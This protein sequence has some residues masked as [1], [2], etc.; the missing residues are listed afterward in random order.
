MT[1]INIVPIIPKKFLSLNLSK[2]IENQLEE[3][4]KAIKVD[5]EVTTRTWK[6]RPSFFI[7]AIPNG[8]RIYTDN[9]VYM[10]IDRGTK[11]HK[12]SARNAK[13][14]AFFAGGFRAK[15]RPRFIGSNKGQVANKN[16]TFPQSVNHPG[17]PAREYESTIKDKWDKEAP[18]QFLRALRAELEKR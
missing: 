7:K 9:F 10:L 1:E 16:L 14:L 12:I 13:T 4:A 18:R 8:R 3:T 2:V 6:E 11:A 5:F 17:F 15:T